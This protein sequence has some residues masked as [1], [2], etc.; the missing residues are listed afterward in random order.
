MSGS[1]MFPFMFPSWE[2]IVLCS[3]ATAASS[4][5]SEAAGGAGEPAASSGAGDDSATS[6]CTGLAAGSLALDSTGTPS[7]ACSSIRGD[8]FKSRPAGVLGIHCSDFCCS[9]SCPG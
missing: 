7:R 2:T 6:R 5:A 3:G 9:A 1:F 4:I 8:T